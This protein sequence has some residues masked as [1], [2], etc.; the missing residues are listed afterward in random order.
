VPWNFT[1]CMSALEQAAPFW[2]T[3]YDQAVTHLT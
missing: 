3:A 2:Q 1:G